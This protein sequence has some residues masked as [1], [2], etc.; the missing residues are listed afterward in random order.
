ME[1]DATGWSAIIWFWEQAGIFLS[2]T[3]SKP[4]LES[5]GSLCTLGNKVQ[6][7]QKYDA[8]H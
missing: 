2:T 8:A 7:G 6:K 5:Q 1:C 3:L 4:A